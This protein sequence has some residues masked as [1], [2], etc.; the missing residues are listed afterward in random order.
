MANKRSGYGRA[1]I[2]CHAAQEHLGTH[3]VVYLD[4][5]ALRRRAQA[6]PRLFLDSFEGPLILDEAARAPAL[7]PELK[8]RVDEERRIERDSGKPSAADVWITG[9]NQTLLRGEVQESLAGRATYLDLNTLSAHELG[10]LFSIN[11]YFF[12]GGW[13]ELYVHPELDPIRY[14]NDLIA[15]FVERDIVSAA[16]IEKKSAFTRVLQ[17]AAGRVGELLNNSELASA[18]GVAVTTVQAWLSILEDNGLIYQLPAYYTNINKRLI[19]APKF[20]F[21][22]TGLATRLQGWTELQP[23]LSSPLVGHLFENI[24]VGEV[25]RFFFNRGLPPTLSFLRSKEKVEVDLIVHLPNRRA[26]AIEVKRSAQD[27]TDRQR[28]LLDSTDLNIIERWV[29]APH[30]SVGL[31]H[32]KVVLIEELWDALSGV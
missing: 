5:A 29:V 30:R 2:L 27:Y 31:Q 19:K 12:S 15:T 24:V 25:L 21:I 28:K 16:G 11:R 8:R 17:L 20:F 1:R 26:L 4:D 13:P 9:S 3:E 18:S 22:D 23:L 7:F 14:L 10:E 32:S 6:D